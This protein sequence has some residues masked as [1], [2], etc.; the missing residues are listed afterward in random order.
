MKA[1]DV[2]NVR[3]HIHLTYTATDAKHSGVSSL[4]LVTL[5]QVCETLSGGEDGAQVVAAG[6]KIHYLY[7]LGFRGIFFRFEIV[8]SP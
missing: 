8:F 1:P 2:C 6:C 5:D 4:L 3:N 7:F